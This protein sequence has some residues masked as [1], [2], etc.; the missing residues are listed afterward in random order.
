MSSSNTTRWKQ[1][2]D[3]LMILV[4]QQ[5]QKR[6]ALQDLLAEESKAWRIG[7]EPQFV[8]I[9][10]I[11]SNDLSLSPVGIVLATRIVS[12]KNPPLTQSS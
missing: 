1:G 11:A 12:P 8:S 2:E 3:D 7:N 5:Q 6:R 4:E 9:K 10:L